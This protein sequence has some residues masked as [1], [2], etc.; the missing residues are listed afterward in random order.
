MNFRN[1][2]RRVF[3]IATA[4]LNASIV[5]AAPAWQTEKVEAPRVSYHTFESRAA[6]AKVSY[7][8]YTPAAYS[9]DD[10]RR[11]PVVYWLHG[12][13]GGSRGIRPLA[14]LVD[15]AIQSGRTPPFL[16]VFVN[17]L[18]LGMYVDWKDGSAPIETVITQDL[19]QHI[20]AN[21][22]TVPTR[23][24]R[25]LDGFSMGGYGAARLGFKFPELF[26]AVS[27]IGAGPLQRTLTRAPRASGKTADDV[28]QEVYGGDIE[29]F[30]AVSPRQLAA[31]NA[32]IIRQESLIRI[33]IGDRDETFANNRDFHEYLV[34]LDIPHDWIVIEGVGHDPMSVLQALGDQHWAFY[35]EAFK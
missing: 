14:Q 1:V 16:V 2:I 32:E 7:H 9:V 20:D 30:R 3:V 12:S 23:C 15:Q 31:D 27:I 25:L 33:V 28:M 17:G 24:G 18:R 22:R 21:Y 8:L 29:Y 10:G 4:V 19:L 26:G 11:Y 5:M 13:G 34:A 35:R 6:Q